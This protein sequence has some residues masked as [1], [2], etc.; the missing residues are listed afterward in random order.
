ML[1]ARRGKKN[2]RK[3]E[4]DEQLKKLNYRFIQELK[5]VP[6]F[7]TL[8][9]NKSYLDELFQDSSDFVIREFKI[10]NSL[11]AIMF[12]I[13]GMVNT[14]LVNDAM[15]SLMILEGEE[16][17][18]DN[19]TD[20]TL[21]V[22]QIQKTDNYSDLLLSVLGGDTG[23]IV[24]RNNKALMM[25]IRGMEKRSINEPD[26]ESVVRGPRE[27]FVENLRTNTSMVRRKLKTPHLKMKPLTL[28]RE[29]NTS[30]V[31]AYLHNLAD[32]AIVEEVVQRLN[33][34]DI[35]AV[36]ES[37]YIE[38]FIQDSAYSPF[39]QIQYTE[40]PDVVAASLLQGRVAIMVDGTPF[41]M[42][43]PFVFAE[44]LQAS[45]DFYERFQIA[46]LIRWLRYVFLILSLL[47]PGMYVAITTYHQ[48][49]LPTTL[50][51]S[52]AAAREAIPF[53]AVVEA[54]IMEITFEA[55]R[56][57][58]IRLPKAIGSAVSILGALVVG[59]AAVE[60]GIVSAPMV[61]VVSI[62]GIASFTIPRFNGAI[63]IRMLRFPI[64]IAASLFGMYGI[65]ISV[66][67]ILGHMATL[68]S[69]GVPY[70]SPIGPLSSSD[71]KD[72][73]IR[74]PW[75]TMRNRPAY[76]SLQD[77]QRIGEE[78]PQEIM[79]QGGQKGKT[80]RHEQERGGDV[81]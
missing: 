14:D 27:G 67:L 21:P 57:A 38:E 69:F 47:T 25:G 60:A 33:K 22:S 80:I 66:M 32:P 70:L 46:T 5:S 75:W 64:M 12:F 79:D 23:L 13:D 8:E 65:M 20:T 4:R 15:K 2:R 19:I 63:A 24:E 9:E 28:G 26:T 74:A 36:L 51:L 78:L 1:I 34:V 6:V 11:N 76:L 62:T 31:V 44:I 59:Q 18:I 42:I 55:L 73:M 3:E 53:P 71:L 29:S 52:V 37:G 17:L 30:I 16:S 43:V 40:R 61:I 7:M 50:L 58:G 81:E 56:E 45:E 49:L 72:V 68:R 39:P 77:T 10:Q 48:D 54:L 35:D 41:V